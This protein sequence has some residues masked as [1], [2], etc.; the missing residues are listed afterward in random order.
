LGQTLNNGG[1][2]DLSVRVRAL[3]TEHRPGVLVID[4][5]KAL[6]AYA[7]SP[8]AFRGFLHG[9]AGILTAVAATTFWV[10]E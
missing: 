3:I 9:L 5:F 6:S 8:K 1:L 10:G 4:S 7:A 2:D